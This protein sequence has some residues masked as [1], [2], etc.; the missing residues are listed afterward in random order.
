MTSTMR[1]QVRET[2]MRIERENDGR[3]ELA[4][5][6]LDRLLTEAGEG[7]SEDQVS[8]M[9]GTDCMQCGPAIEEQKFALLGLDV[10]ALFPSMSAARTGAIVR[11]RIMASNITPAGFDWKVGLVYILMN[12]NKTSNLGELKKILPFR[13]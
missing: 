7:L 9:T 12:K 8:K 4:E 13:R 11:K 10:E 3:A 1:D 6:E 2:V 5:E